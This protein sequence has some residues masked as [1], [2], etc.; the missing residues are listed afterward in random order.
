MAGMTTNSCSRY[1]FSA[2]YF[3]FTSI[4]EPGNLLHLK[5]AL[6]LQDIGSDKISGFSCCSSMRNSQKV[7]S[8][9]KAEYLS[10]LAAGINACSTPWI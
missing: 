10:S 2:L 3:S 5:E 9:A 1:F 4:K 6:S 8:A 7:T